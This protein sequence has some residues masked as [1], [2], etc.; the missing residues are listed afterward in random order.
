MAI[1]TYSEMRTFVNEHILLYL[2]NINYV[3]PGSNLYVYRLKGY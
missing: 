1:K 2:S 3:S